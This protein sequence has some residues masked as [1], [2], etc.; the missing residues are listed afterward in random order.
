[1]NKVRRYCNNRYGTT[2]CETA[3]ELFK[4]TTKSA[5][6][7]IDYH[8]FEYIDEIVEE[9]ASNKSLQHKSP[10]HKQKVK[11]LQWSN[12]FDADYWT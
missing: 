6:G 2:F 4:Q 9:V 10:E 12:T 5:A 7:S 1:M 11:G 3:E 8:A